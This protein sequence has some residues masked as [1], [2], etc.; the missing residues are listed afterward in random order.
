MPVFLRGSFKQEYPEQKRV[1]EAR[2]IRQ[3]YPDRI[4]IIVEQA[5]DQDFAAV[6]MKRK[7]LVAKMSHVKPSKRKE[8]H[9]LLDRMLT[10][11]PNVR[12]TVD[13]ALQHPFFAKTRASRRSQGELGPVAPHRELIE[14]NEALL[15]DDGA[16][17]PCK[18]Q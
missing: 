8:I 13:E 3:K 7:Y 12:I 17:G 1:M 10:E 2:R 15:A 14:S 9:D 5:R 6:D 11:D 18:V 16:A 4:P